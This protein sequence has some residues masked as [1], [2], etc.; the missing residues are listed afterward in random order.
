MK[1]DREHLDGTSTDNYRDVTSSGVPSNGVTMTTNHRDVTST[2]NHRDVTSN[3]FTPLEAEPDHA[4]AVPTAQVHVRRTTVPTP[5]FMGFDVVAEQ[6]KDP[7]I[8]PVYQAV[9]NAEPMPEAAEMSKHSEDTKNLMAQ[10]P[11]LT[12]SND[13]LYRRWVDGKKNTR[14]LQ[15][16]V[17]FSCRKQVMQLAHQG[18]T[19]GHYGARK[20]LCPALPT[21][22]LEIMA[23]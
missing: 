6:Q 7:D 11:L 2:L 20:N 19:G 17:P 22:V 8:A 23:A 9:C 10:W 14:W 5:A 21:S 3:Y 4:K 16:V 12:V 13:V 15:C 1:L 18:L